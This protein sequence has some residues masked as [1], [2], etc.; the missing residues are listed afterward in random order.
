MASLL[1]WLGLL[2][3]LPQA[4]YVQKTAVRFQ[5]ASGLPRGTIGQG[6]PIKLLGVGDSVIAGVGVSLFPLSLTAQLATEMAA[7]GECRVSW[8]ALGR[9]GLNAREV[10]RLFCDQAPGQSVNLMLV[11]VGVNDTTG[12]KSLKHWRHSLGQLVDTLHQHSPEALII[13][14]GL[15]PMQHFP[16]LPRP[17]RWVIGLRAWQL[18]Q[19][20]RELAQNHVWL[21]QIPLAFRPEPCQFADDGYHPSAESCTEIAR[22]IVAALPPAWVENHREA[23]M[24]MGEAAESGRGV[25]THQV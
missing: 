25:H 15:P 17:L 2:I 9:T 3:S 22:A 4:L 14:L 16:L 10:R 8:S 1:F 11:S 23:E 5:G 12:L 19:M 18:E 24:E 21:Q 20:A 7:T 6:P 13:L